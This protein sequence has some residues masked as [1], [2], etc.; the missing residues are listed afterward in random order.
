VL[1]LWKNGGAD[2]QPPRL[3]SKSLKVAPRDELLAALRE[4]LGDDRVRLHREPPSLGAVPQRDEPWRN[5]R[6]RA[7]A[8]A[9]E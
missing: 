4:C 6:P 9:E 1:V 3:R 7:G 5:R 8:A 2:A